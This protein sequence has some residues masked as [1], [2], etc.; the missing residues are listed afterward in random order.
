MLQQLIELFPNA[1][2][3]LNHVAANPTVDPRWFIKKF[4]WNPYLSANEGLT[5]TFIKEHID[6]KWYWYS[7]SMNPRL[8]LEIVEEFFNKPW[9]FAAISAKILTLEFLTKHLDKDWC[10]NDIIRQ[11]YITLDNLKIIPEFEMRA[12][13]LS[14]NKNLTEEFVL[15]HPNWNWNWQRLNQKFSKIIKFKEYC[16]FLTNCKNSEEIQK[17]LKVC[18]GVHGFDP[19]FPIINY[20]NKK[21]SWKF[22]KFDLSNSLTLTEKFIGEYFDSFVP[23]HFAK[24]PI[25]TCDIIEKYLKDSFDWWAISY[26]PNL[27]IEFITKFKHKI[28][29]HCLSSNLFLADKDSAAYKEYCLHAK[30][31]LDLPDVLFHI[32][33]SYI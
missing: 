27:T 30:V 10:W 29:F 1:A 22:D 28:S 18:D 5:I 19:H 2:W 24:N 14:E 3:Y 6:E 4:G 20:F 23:E 7:L 33:T 26:N 31:A 21:N 15:Q 17:H 11:S 16:P 13:W 25:V 32:I 8:P 9:V 12:Y